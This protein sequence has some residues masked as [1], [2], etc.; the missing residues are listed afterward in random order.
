MKEFDDDSLTL[1]TTLE[2][3]N[4]RIEIEDCPNITFERRLN[5][6]KQ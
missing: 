5:E 3:E 4:I 2:E 6:N 1:I